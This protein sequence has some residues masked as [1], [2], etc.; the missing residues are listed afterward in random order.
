MNECCYFEWQDRRP[1]CTGIDD[2]Q[3]NEFEC[4][5]FPR[6]YCET[7]PDCAWSSVD[8]E[9]DTKYAVKQTLTKECK[10]HPESEYC[11]NYGNITSFAI[12]TLCCCAF[13]GFC[14]GLK[15]MRDQFS[16]R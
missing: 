16:S 14:A 2:A 13:C 9:C 11:D 3:Y 15:F 8:Y 5:D 10:Q 7:D 6:D 12:A 1:M 4:S